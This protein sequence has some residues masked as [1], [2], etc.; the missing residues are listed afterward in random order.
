M[1]RVNKHKSHS[2][3]LIA[4]VE[5]RLNS[6]YKQKIPVVHFIAGSTLAGTVFP[7]AGVASLMGLAT[8]L[9]WMIGALT[10]RVAF[11]FPSFST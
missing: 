6:Q 8:F 7:P 4:K 2:E 9:T 1:V 11:I 5:I 3:E 10:T